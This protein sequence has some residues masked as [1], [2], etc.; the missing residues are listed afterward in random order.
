METKW[1]MVV[2]KLVPV[3]VARV[4]DTPTVISHVT[5]YNTK[6]DKVMDT[7]I[8]HPGEWPTAPMASACTVLCKYGSQFKRVESRGFEFPLL[9]L[10]NSPLVDTFR[11][12]AISRM[13][14]ELPLYN[15]SVWAEDAFS[16]RA[17]PLN[18]LFHFH[19]LSPYRLVP[20]LLASTVLHMYRHEPHYSS[21]VKHIVLL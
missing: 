9:F 6:V 20:A 15:S 5:A 19:F 2:P 17:S 13:T 11:L 1:Q 16:L 18:D 3:N 14:S 10:N 21:Y 4:Q 12:F 8:F 7:L